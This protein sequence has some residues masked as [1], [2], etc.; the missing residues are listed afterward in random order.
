MDINS[1]K[2]VYKKVFILCK[3]CFDLISTMYICI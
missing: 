3:I 2:V 1:K